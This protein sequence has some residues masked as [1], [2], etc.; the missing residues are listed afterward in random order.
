MKVAFILFAQEQ[1]LRRHFAVSGTSMVP[2]EI[3][4]KHGSDYKFFTQPPHIEATAYSLKIR[5]E[6]PDFAVVLLAEQGAQFQLTTLGLPLSVLE[7]AQRGIQLELSR[8]LTFWIK[9]LSSIEQIFKPMGNRKA[10]LLPFKNFNDEAAKALWAS[11][12]NNLSERTFALA[13]E[14]EK[15]VSHLRSREFPKRKG[16]DYRDKY[17]I[18]DRGYHFQYGHEKHSKPV[19]EGDGHT[20]ECAMN[21]RLRLGLPYEYERHYNLSLEDNSNLKGHEF[22]NCHGIESKADSCDHL[23][24]FPNSFIN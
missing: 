10:L 16:G 8:V 13:I 19:I 1:Q 4:D 22:I 17:F 23:N 7:I 15:L 20:N 6:N 12:T 9:R 3:R 2:R 11:I 5:A 18:D 21:S 14:I 24:I